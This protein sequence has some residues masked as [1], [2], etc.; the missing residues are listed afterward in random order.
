MYVKTEERANEREMENTLKS[1]E[2]ESESEI[3]ERSLMVLR[4]AFK[5]K[6]PQ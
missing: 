6:F 1:S 3:E 4:V 2:S 5:S